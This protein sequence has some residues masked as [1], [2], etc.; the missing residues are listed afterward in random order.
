MPYIYFAQGVDGGPIKIGYTAQQPI[1]RLK[2]LQTAHHTELRLTR[3]V[4]GTREMESNLHKLFAS[5][6]IRGEWFEAVPP[7][8]DLANAIPEPG[9]NVIQYPKA[10]ARKLRPPRP[11]RWGIDE[12][13]V[14]LA[15]FQALHA[16]PDEDEIIRRI[17]AGM[18]ANRSRA[19]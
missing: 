18:P 15:D 10:P 6:R 14:D 2:A 4:E 19:A 8:A 12:A 1:K 16:F 9:P 11:P 17:D 5:H 7:L 3:F 13:K